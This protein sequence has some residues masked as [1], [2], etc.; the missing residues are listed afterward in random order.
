[1]KTMGKVRLMAYAVVTLFAA[2]VWGAKVGVFVGDGV[3]GVDPRAGCR[4]W[5][6]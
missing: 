2:S 3:Q 6:A 5:A 1:M 4:S